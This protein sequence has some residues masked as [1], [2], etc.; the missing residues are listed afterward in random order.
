MPC[1]KNPWKPNRK[2][3]L[4]MNGLLWFAQISLALAFLYAGL[5]RVLSFGRQPRALGA[6]AAAGPIWRSVAFGLLEIVGAL[7]VVL[8]FDIWPPYILP[9]LAAA[10]LALLAI[11][12]SAYQARRQGPAAPIMALFFIALFVILGRWP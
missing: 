10:G 12:A 4:T 7:A 2:G 3:R 9:R 11:P 6:Q 1:K 5:R 8:P